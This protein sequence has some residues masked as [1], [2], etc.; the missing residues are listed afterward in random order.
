C[1]IP[2]LVQYETR[3]NAIFASCQDPLLCTYDRS[4]FGAAEAM[5]AFGAHHLG[6]AGGV[7]QENPLLGGPIAFRRSREAHALSALRRRFLMAL[8]AGDRQDE[9][10]IV[11]EQGLTLAVPLTSLY[12][13]VV[14][15]P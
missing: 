8:L 4:Q 13:A 9:L 7:V 1:G 11:I 10:D 15:P 12:L 2:K 6:I 3:V 14:Q 5:D